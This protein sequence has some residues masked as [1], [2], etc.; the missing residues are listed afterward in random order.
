MSVHL[1]PLTNFRVIAV[2]FMHYLESIHVSLIQALLED[3]SWLNTTRKVVVVSWD[4]CRFVVLWE[5]RCNHGV[6]VYRHESL[7]TFWTSL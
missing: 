3:S 6:Y 4:H 1:C 2:I 7:Q 5:M